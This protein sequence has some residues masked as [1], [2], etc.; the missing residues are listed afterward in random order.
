MG[1]NIKRNS[2]DS[3]F[4]NIFKD[5][6]N[7]VDLYYDISGVRL[8]EEDIRVLDLE[9]YILNSIKNDLSFITSD[10]KLI[11][12]IE[13]QSSINYNMDIRLLLYYSRL[14][15]DYIDEKYERGLHTSRKIELPNAEFYILYNGKSSIDKKEKLKTIINIGDKKIDLGTKIIDINYEKLSES[16]IASKDVLSSYSYLIK[17]YN[18]NIIRMREEQS[19]KEISL[20]LIEA[21]TQ[22]LNDCKL[23]GL[24]L[25]LFA[26]KEFRTMALEALSFEEELEVKFEM[27]K[28]MGII[29]GEEKGRKEE[30]LNLA[31]SM[32]VNGADKE[33]VSKCT[34]LSIEEV[35]AL[36]VD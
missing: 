1:N 12:L 6:K 13:H 5:K 19:D 2:K 11:V 7:L 30:R 24:Y 25:D 4:R 33:F 27:G 14:L 23:N 28:Y 3:I 36:Q 10:D 9:N 21:F 15:E 35:E 8:R 18:D 29:E 31:K 22:A 17:S 26:R 20:I 16:I 34:K 32:L